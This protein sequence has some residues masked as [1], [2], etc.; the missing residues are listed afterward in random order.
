VADL[1][2][3]LPVSDIHKRLPSIFPEGCPNR[4]NC[5]WDIAA[6]TI[7]VML[8]VGAIEGRDVWIRPDQV[9]R[10]TDAQSVLHDKISR[11]KWAEISRKSSR[12]E[13]PGR[14]YAVNTR[15]SI[16]D[17]TLRS[18]LIAN[19]AVVERSGLPTTSPAPRYALQLDFAD[20]FNPRLKGKK[21]KQAIA[22]WQETN[23]SSGAIARITMRRRG[24]TD[25]GKHVV[26]TFPNGE[27][28]RMVP[29]PS[30]LISKAVIEDFSKR[31]LQEPGVIFLSE[32]ANKIVARDD[33][34][35]KSINLSIEADKNLPDII[36]TD[37]GPSHPFL[38]F[39]E[40]VATDGPI[41]EM[42]KAALQKIAE[43][44]GFSERHVVFVTAYLDRSDR[45]FKKTVDSLSWGTF[46]WFASEPEKLLVLHEGQVKSSKKLIDF[47]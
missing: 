25:D 3:L 32:S 22:A 16:R 44:A 11:L 33:E 17:D 21:L 47:L 14:W 9:T 19:G 4:N 23:L 5:V 26:I 40:V 2:A 45:A 42:R 7:F 31:F 1:P 24:V 36:M 18:A 29:G 28:R 13:T 15:E 35:A 12:G 37:L 8:Y 41:N 20:L 34:L 10:M 39:V 38:V 27:T 6:R 30:A 43:N 46:A